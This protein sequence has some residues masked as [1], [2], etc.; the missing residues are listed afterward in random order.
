MIEIVA[1]QP[2][3]AFVLD[4]PEAYTVW[5]FEL[6]N[7][8]YISFEDYLDLDIENTYVEWENGRVVCYMANN[9]VHQ[10]IV[11]FLLRLFGLYLE[12]YPI[13]EIIVAGYAMKL[14]SQRRGRVPD[15][16]FVSREHYD[17]L[18][19][20]FLNG[21]AD[22]AV[23]VI[24]RESVKRDREIKFAEYRIAGVKEYWLID[25]QQK[26]AEFYRLNGDGV[27]VVVDFENGEYCTPLLPAF[28]LRTEWLWRDEMPHG[29]AYKGLGLLG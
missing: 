24:S 13:G 11:G 2:T 29:E 3:N 22:I 18:D 20:R 27:Y 26:L 19:P 5:S 17:R 10:R 7:G 15:L 28:F 6:G 12:K 21:A 14:E 25:P 16:L 9:L 23:E 8:D 4:V 1:T